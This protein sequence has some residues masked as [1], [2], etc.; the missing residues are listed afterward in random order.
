MDQATQQTCTWLPEEHRAPLHLACSDV[1]QRRHRCDVVRSD[2]AAA[3]D[4]DAH[5]GGVHI[6]R[7]T[8]QHC[9]R[10]MCRWAIPQPIP[11]CNMIQQSDVVLREVC[12]MKS[13]A[14]AQQLT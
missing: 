8:Q 14:R 6:I 4:G 1:R 9:R 7:Q 11:V 13:S 5:D 2:G 10:Q 12:H 3:A